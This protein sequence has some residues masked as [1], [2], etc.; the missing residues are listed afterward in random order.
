MAQDTKYL[1]ILHSHMVIIHHNVL[2]GPS[3]NT[4]TSITIPFTLPPPSTNVYLLILLINL[5]SSLILGIF[6]LNYPTSH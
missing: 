4:I 5:I 6:S 1:Q 3:H 2:N